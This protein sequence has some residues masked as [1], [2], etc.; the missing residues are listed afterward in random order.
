[1]L[2]ALQQLAKEPRGRLGIAPALDQDV[3]HVA[4]LIHRAPEMVQLAADADEHL[5]HESLVA[6]PWPT[7]LQRGGEQ[8]AEAQA[9][10]ADA[11]L[12]NH[13]AV[14]GEDQLDVTQAQAEAV[15][16]PDRM[17]DHLGWIAKATIRIGRHC[18][19]KQAAMVRP[20]PLT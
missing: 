10:C 19:A 1:V 2:Q 14:G 11:L 13:D 12:A 9:L 3:E 4:V 6:W 17:L 20:G 16:Q 8:P 18:H 15:I 7:P 5:V